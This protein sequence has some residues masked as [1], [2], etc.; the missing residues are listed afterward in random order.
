MGQAKK[1]GLIINPIAG[2]GGR[3][4]LKGTDG[5]EVLARAIQLGA[6]PRAQERVR[7]ALNQIASMHD[8]LR[9]LTFPGAMGEFAV[10]SSGMAPN[11]LSS[12]ISELTSAEDTQRAAA[13]MRQEGVDLL[14]FAGGDGTA[15]DICSVVG[16]DLICLGIPAGVKI[17]S[18]VFSLNPA[19]GG[20][21]ACEYLMG[22]IREVRACEVMDIDETEF[23]RGSLSS[24]LYGYLSI[25][26]K[27]QHSQ[28]RKMRTPA[29][30]RYAQ[31]AV[32]AEIS[33]NLRESATYMVGPGTTTR[34]ILEALKLPASLLGVDVV[35][36]R[37]LVARDA[38]ES[39]LLAWFQPGNTRLILTPVGGQ[40][41]ILGRGNQQISP[42]I[43][44]RL[45]KKDIIIAATPQ[46]IGAL[47]GAALRVDTGDVKLD[48]NLS[49]YYRIVT[50]CGESVIYR[51]CR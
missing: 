42:N 6:V 17:H 27:K 29:P 49:G 25:P 44:S 1:L 5:P 39:T 13:L 51:V 19:I 15:R 14:L 28:N 22:R 30:E 16:E 8:K 21:L 35:R 40:G 37:I 2:M 34:M 20:R 50:G 43:L 10:R 24:R 41:F 7:E 45:S 46:K 18:A 11:L 38:D 4:G 47:R 23:R 31:Q 32:A 48:H 26:Y 3:V 33:A 12:K 36:N 9:I